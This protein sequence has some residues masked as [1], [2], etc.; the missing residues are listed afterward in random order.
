MANIDY[1]YNDPD[2]L[3]QAGMADIEHEQFMYDQM[4]YGYNAD[5]LDLRRNLLENQQYGYDLYDD[6]ANYDKS[7][8]AGLRKHAMSGPLRYLYNEEQKEGRKSGYVGQASFNRQDKGNQID[9]NLDQII[10][11]WEK[12][13][14]GVRGKSVG[15]L[16]DFIADVYRHEYKH[17]LYKS[18]VSGVGMYQDPSKVQSPHY[19][20]NR[21]THRDIHS[22]GTLFGKSGYSVDQARAALNFMG[23]GQNTTPRRRRPPS[24]RPSAPVRAAAVGPP[25]YNY[26]TGGLV[27]LACQT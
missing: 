27:S 26:S 11:E 23:S 4:K 6:S 25:G 19:N 5:E 17:P 21:L 13:K 20:A 9:L 24:A 1:L 16:Q 14:E 10:E 8:I 15:T 7:G 3:L 2:W 22:S 12:A 18:A